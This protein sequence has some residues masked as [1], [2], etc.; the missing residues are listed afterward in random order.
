MWLTSAMSQVAVLDRSLPRRCPRLFAGG[1][2]G[3][4]GHVGKGTVAVV[5]EQ[6]LFLGAEHGRDEQ[7]LPAVVVDVQEVDAPGVIAHYPSMR[8]LIVGE[9]TT[10]SAQIQHVAPW[11]LLE[12]RVPE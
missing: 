11:R 1:D 5:G 7:V 12:R 2:S 9:P 3:M 8:R 10:R 6:E 4:S